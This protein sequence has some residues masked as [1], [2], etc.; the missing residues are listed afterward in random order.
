MCLIKRL[1][2]AICPCEHNAFAMNTQTDPQI[3][4]VFENDV[5]KDLV[6]CGSVSVD[7]Q[8]AYTIPTKQII[9]K[10]RYGLPFTLRDLLPIVARDNHVIVTGVSYIYRYVCHRFLGPARLF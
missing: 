10:E 9:G 5:R 2:P 4:N 3:V 8:D 7:K 1:R 6:K